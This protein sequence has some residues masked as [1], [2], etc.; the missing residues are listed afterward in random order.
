MFFCLFVLS[1]LLK[2]ISSL[3]ENLPLLPNE[4]SRLLKSQKVVIQ[5]TRVDVR[6][7]PGL[8]FNGDEKQSEVQANIVL[9]K[10]MFE[11][12]DRSKRAEEQI[13]KVG[14]TLYRSNKLFQM[15]SE[16]G[17][18]KG[19]SVVN[20]QTISAS[21][22]GFKIESL[23]E[24]IE[25]HFSTLNKDGQG[26]STCVFWDFNG[27]GAFIIIVVVFEFFLFLCLIIFVEWCCVCVL[28]RYSSRF[29]L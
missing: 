24:P 22:R 3:A 17:I 10:T 25:T 29:L 26:I 11:G 14:F 18:K 5:T 15:V 12:R 27:A 2:A 16:P 6:S 20:S 19:R 1:R 8:S 21:V 23:A 9:P 4:T 7:F 13:T 28:C